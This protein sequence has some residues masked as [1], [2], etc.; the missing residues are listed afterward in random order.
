MI[1]SRIGSFLESNANTAIGFI[2]SMLIWQFVVKPIWGFKTGFADNFAITSVFT[3][4]SIFRG[5]WVRRYFNWRL[6]RV[7]KRELG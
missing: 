6:H 3:V 7:A 1:Q 5:Y 2:G 4:W